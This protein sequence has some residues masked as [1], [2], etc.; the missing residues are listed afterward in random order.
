MVQAH[1]SLQIRINSL[2]DTLRTG[3]VEMANWRGGT[4]A[5][6]AVPG[7][8][9]S[10]G[11]SVAA[12]IAIVQRI[13]QRAIPL[14]SQAPPE[15]LLVTF[16]R[17]AALHLKRQIRRHLAELQQP[18]TGFTV[19]TLHGMALGIAAQHPL[20]SGLNLEQLTLV[21]PYRSHRLIQTVI[22]RWIQAHPQTFQD[23]IEQGGWTGEEAERLRRQSV[24]RTDIL[25]ALATLV[26][27]EAKSSGLS[28]ADLMALS[29]QGRENSAILATAAALY[30]NYQSELLAQR[31]IDYE[32]MILG[33][34]RSLQ[35][36]SVREQWQRRIFA[37]FE[38]EAQDSSPLQAKLVESLAATPQDPQT[39]NLIRVGDPN[40]AIN[41]TFTPANP[42]L[43]RDFCHHQTLQGK[44]APLHHAGRSS[45]AIIR[46]VNRYM[47]WALQQSPATTDPPFIRQHIQPVPPED[48]QPQANPLPIG[49]GI[50]Q[51]HPLDIFQTAEGIA[52]RTL[53]LIHDQPDLT[54]AVLVRE[55]R[56]A[57]FLAE[58]LSQP[59]I[60]GLKTDVTSANLQILDAG[61]Q[62]RLTTVPQDL[63]TLLKFIARPHSS[64]HLNA[65]LRLLSD[66]QIIAPLAIDQHSAY[67]EQ[68][69]Y[70]MAEEDLPETR[71]ARSLCVKLLRSRWEL[72]LYQLLSFLGL[73]LQYEPEELATADKLVQHLL[74]LNQGKNSLSQW[75]QSLEELLRTERFDGVELDPDQ[76]DFCRD[77]Q[78]TIMTM[79]KAKGLDWDV[80]FLPFLHESL[81]FGPLMPLAQ[82]RFLGEG[83]LPEVARQQLRAAVQGQ[84]IPNA[85]AAWDQA[86]QLKTAED[87]RLLYVAMTRPRRLL[88][89]SACDQ[90]P[91]RW[92]HYSWQRQDPLVRQ[93]PCR[94][95][96]EI[97]PL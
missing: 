81:L 40:Q 46:Y 83:S 73:A 87:Y 6:S 79:H 66:R 8:G 20:Q 90:A 44:F 80:V 56:Q 52:Q 51:Y 49:V 50:E 21:S 29:T 4:L 16:T 24:L 57:Q 11:I 28:P 23:L 27:R 92:S 64:M 55:N 45:L 60:Y 3:Q 62:A 69:L 84:P 59:A 32:D 10:Y 47:D 38:D 93:R 35:D 77:R 78:I 89:L 91:H 14:Q 17:S 74:R 18:I 22:D 72:P 68:F 67:P 19:Q 26:V 37:V 71:S 75:I 9:K 95:L 33:A 34:L 94:F 15:L 96:N 41:S 76:Q 86:Q 7:S 70:P 88:W 42:A 39:L 30:E 61:L 2:R 1:Q 5:V 48:P 65:V 13:H 82:A 58:V 25:P 31:C 63:L 43:F 36:P 97:S 85:A 12:A 54:F 53:A